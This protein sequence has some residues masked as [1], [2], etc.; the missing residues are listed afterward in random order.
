MR[1]HRSSSPPPGP[2]L[3]HLGSTS[4]RQCHGTR[5][6]ALPVPSLP[7]DGRHKH[8][9]VLA[10]CV[11]DNPRQALP[12]TAIQCP[13]DNKHHHPS[14]PWHHVTTLHPPAHIRPEPVLGQGESSPAVIFQTR[15]S[16]TLRRDA[17]LCEMALRPIYLVRPTFHLDPCA[18]GMAPVVHDRFE[19]TA[20]AMGS[21]PGNRPWLDGLLAARTTSPRGGMPWL[22]VAASPT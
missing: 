8:A 1:S 10:A 22:R 5:V 9:F 17:S 12:P 7:P 14:S 15:P 13:I 19:L 20:L 18:A 4:V 2:A 3:T 6:L 16:C 21:A 11:T